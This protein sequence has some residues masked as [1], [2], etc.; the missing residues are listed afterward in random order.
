MSLPTAI[1]LNQTY[2]VERLVQDLNTAVEHF[3]TASQQ[4]PYH[5]GSWKGIALRSIDGDYRNTG[6]ISSGTSKDTEVLDK[7]PYFKEILHSFKFPMGVARLLFLPPGKKIGEHH[8]KGFG[9]HMGMLRLHIPIITHPDVI[10]MIGGERC[11]WKPGEFW[12]GDFYQ[13]HWLHNQS[14]ITRVHLVIDCFVDEELLTYFPQNSLD[15]VVA[16]TNTPIFVNQRAA[17]M[18]EQELSAYQGYFKLPKKLSPIPLYG[19]FQ[20]KDDK[21]E[22]TLFGVPLPYGFAPVGNQQFRYLDKTLTFADGPNSNQIHIQGTNPAL[23]MDIPVQPSLSLPQQLYVG[24][25][26]GFTKL[27][28]GLLRLS[29]R[30][31]QWMQRMRS[32]H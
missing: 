5:D 30:S 3:Q 23:D 13:P 1:R 15:E 17:K 27:G 31:R 10:F 7:C 18:A 8:D 4:G 2:D 20:G 16:Q 6:A 25:Q 26:I 22:I 19:R 29:M 9:W 28:L 14:D 32:A 21:L 24:L 12:F 11:Q